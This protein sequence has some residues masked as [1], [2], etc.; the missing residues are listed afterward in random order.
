MKR[1]AGSIHSRVQAW[2]GINVG[3]GLRLETQ[4]T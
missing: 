4:E 3:A 2:G 1:S